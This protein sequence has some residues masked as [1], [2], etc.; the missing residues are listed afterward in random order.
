MT[1]SH[2]RDL[3]RLAEKQQGGEHFPGVDRYRPVTLTPGTKL[4]KLEPSSSGY[5][6]PHEEYQKSQGNSRNLSTGV[7]V[8]PRKRIINGQ[9]FYDYRSE[10]SVWTV[11]KPIRAVQG[12]TLANPQYGNG[13]MRQIHISSYRPGDGEHNRQIGLIEHSRCKLRDNSLS[14]KHGDLFAIRLNYHLRMR[15]LFCHLDQL[16]ELK[17]LHCGT[18]TP[19]QQEQ[20]SGLREALQDRVTRYERRLAFTP[21]EQKIPC[22][23]YDKQ[24]DSLKTRLDGSAPLSPSQTEEIKALR[25]NLMSQVGDTIGQVVRGELPYG[26]RNREIH[27][28]ELR[29]AYECHRFVGHSRCLSL[30]QDNTRQLGQV[31]RQLAQI[32]RREKDLL[33]LGKLMHVLMEKQP[34]VGKAEG[35]IFFRGAFCARHADELRE[36]QQARSELKRSG[37]AAPA[38]VTRLQKEFNTDQLPRREI[39]LQERSKL[40]E[41]AQSLRSELHHCE[42]QIQEFNRFLSLG[43][44]APGPRLS[45]S[46]LSM[47][48]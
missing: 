22:P 7:Q 44:A 40:L 15:N 31:E 19:R 47:R 16:S 1:D 34:L 11:E 3:V 37:I 38:D 33:R 39:L 41:Q 26:Q 9:K 32:D 21:N 18:L 25:D 14:Q 28:D 43:H 24:I 46:G 6:I 20:I 17:S 45:P 30:I 42:R 4:V 29:T 23:S 27:V 5:F 48:P 12:P 10:L 35:K 2:D 13:G 36:H 8:A